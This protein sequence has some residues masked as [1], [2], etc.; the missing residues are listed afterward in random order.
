MMN[1]ITFIPCQSHIKNKLKKK[2]GERKKEKRKKKGNVFLITQCGL[3]H[4]MIQLV[5]KYPVMNG[6]RCKELI[7]KP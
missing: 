7:R 3:N 5:Y 2:K 6:A 1:Q 4:P